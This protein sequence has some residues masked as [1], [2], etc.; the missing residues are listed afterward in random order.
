MEYAIENYQYLA[1]DITE[2]L[3][4]VKVNEGIPKNHDIF[5]DATVE[6]AIDM[7]EK[8]KNELLLRNDEQV[9]VVYD[10]KEKVDAPIKKGTKIGTVNYYLGEEKMGEHAIIICE[11]VE[12]K[13]L[14]WYWSAILNLYLL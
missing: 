10:Y 7:S 5:Q 8:N 12:K 11:N 6:I 1:I 13:T 9:E 14:R 2:E 3:P 4:E